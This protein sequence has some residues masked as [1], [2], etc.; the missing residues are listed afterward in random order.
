M[1]RLGRN[2]PCPCGSGKK[3][4]KCCESS[5]G[6][7]A[8]YTRADREVALAALDEL[9]S[10]PGWERLEADAE[11]EFWGELDPEETALAD[12]ETLELMS[13]Q[14]FDWWFFFDYEHEPGRYVV[15]A[16]L[17]LTPSLP[18]GARSFLELARATT[19]RV[20]Q[21]TEVRPGVGM[22]LR[23]AVTGRETRVGERL[24]S[25][26][27]RRWD[28]IATRIMPAGST[29]DPVLDGGV[30]PIAMDRAEPLIEWLRSVV[31]SAAGET[32]E[33]S[34]KD[35]YAS[36]VP[37]IHRAWV[38]PMAA[39][40]LVN[41]DGDPVLLARAY[42]DLAQPEAAFA[43]LDAAGELERVEPEGEPPRWHWSGQGRD[44]KEPVLLGWVTLDGQ[45]LVL[46]TNSAERAERGRKLIE[47]IVGTAAT[48]RV[49]RTEAIEQAMESL[50]ARGP[51]RE[52]PALPPELREA[53]TAALEQ[54]L[55]LHLEQ[56]V[57]ERVPRLGDTTP[58]EA[59]A[60]AELRPRVVE[61]LKEHEVMYEK[62]LSSGQAAADPTW[63]WDE[64]GLAHE[65]DAP[66][67]RKQAPVLGHEALYRQFPELAPLTRDVA[68]RVGRGVAP[69]ELS[70][71][72]S[73][74]DLA[75][76]L[77][78]QRFARAC[79][80]PEFARHAALA[81]SNYELYLRKV[82]WV[83]ESLSWLL[84]ATK[85]DVT[86]DA[87]RLPF[88]S[89]A[90][91]FTDRYAL[92][93]AERMDSRLPPEVRTG[94]MLQV[95]TVYLTQTSGEEGDDEPRLV[96]LTLVGDVLDGTRPTVVPCRIELK[97]DARLD[98]ILQTASP[99][100]AGL[101]EDDVV[102]PLYESAPLKD[103]LALVI[104]AL[105]YAT[106]QDAEAREV[107]PAPQRSTQKPERKAPS[108]TAETVFYLP[109]TID[110]KL[111][112]QVKKAR[113]GGREHD[114]T[115]R[116][117]VRGH[118]RRAQQRWEDQRPRWVRPH[119]RGPSAA[120]IVER[121]YRLEE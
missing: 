32:D 9:L 117:M 47:R 21:V 16:L 56:W 3:F 11:A 93:L 76:D 23:D 96:D 28:V 13:E 7:G 64:L 2:E 25:Q 92:G 91:V 79:P 97:N 19:L 65:R 22:V 41:F 87:V 39:P 106:S 62:A 84:G 108:F 40:K 77:A 33:P 82:F 109:G 113:R 90:L 75:R 14:V 111:L 1:S 31:E 85:L 60:S 29:G 52:A 88:R 45:R 48:Y 86:G 102:R 43:A 67:Q 80:S 121:Q 12:N 37:D 18:R 114:L 119:W 81:F 49:T 27:M 71:V 53:G 78:Y 110:I 36:V 98:E 105:L 95:L 34:E 112:E 30:L 15:D 74:D 70:V 54:R 5:G 26:Q 100:V 35:T 58:R 101:E 59:A 4:K 104:N 99:G 8:G 46:E 57:D 116:C 55:T 120:A 6:A 17:K 89:L 115:R 68:A 83:G 50:Q 107:Q 72:V 103:L 10:G 66:G 42:F 118:W 69:T 24:G 63:M 38:A 73:E 94:R 61:M 44:R 20:Y 51:A